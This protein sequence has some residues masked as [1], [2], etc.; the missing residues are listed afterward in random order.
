MDGFPGLFNKAVIISECTPWGCF[1]YKVRYIHKMI[2]QGQ[3]TL[4]GLTLNPDPGRQGGL[5][6]FLK[7]WVEPQTSSR[8]V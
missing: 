6:L 1:E 3:G 2:V 5:L 8:S 7:A 4:A